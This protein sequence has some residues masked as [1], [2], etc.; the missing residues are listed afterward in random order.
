MRDDK[1]TFWFLDASGATRTTSSQTLSI[2]NDFEK[3]AAIFIALSFCSPEQLGAFPA[4][5][6]LPPANSPY[7]A[8]FP[9]MTLKGYAIDLADETDTN[10]FAGD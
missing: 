1:V 3:V 9:P 4:S 10:P 6:I 2:I 5:V 8:S 7:P